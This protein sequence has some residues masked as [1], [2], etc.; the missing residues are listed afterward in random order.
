MPSR[1]KPRDRASAP[2]VTFVATDDGWRLA[3]NLFRPKRAKAG[4]PVVLVLPALGAPARA[5]RRMTTHLAGRGLPVAT[6]DLRGSGASIPLPRRGVD[7]GVDDHLE[8]DLPALLAHLGAAFPKRPVVVIGHSLGGH[9]G[10]FTAA[11]R[12]AALAGLVLL[13]VAKVDRRQFPVAGPILFNLFR[14]LARTLGYVPG[15]RLGFGAPVARTL[16]IEWARWGLRSRYVDIAG[17]DLEAGFDTLALPVLSV[18]F[19][20]D[21]RMGP[22]AACDAFNAL[23]P[24]ERLTAWRIS[25]EEAGVARLDHMA[26]LR[27]APVVWDRIADWLLA[28]AVSRAGTPPRL[29]ARRAPRRGRSP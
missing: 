9:L 24:A 3:L 18:A 27:G 20:D 2:P 19:T 13:T 25:P 29:R 21:R 1:T 26:H 7:F 15:Q 23:L 11:R 4:A 22:R 5:Y 12:P 8:R 16:A 17:R 28:T 14:G 6:A 10:A